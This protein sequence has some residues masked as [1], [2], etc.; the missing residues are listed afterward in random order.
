MLLSFQL[1]QLLQVQEGSIG[2]II[3][4]DL[5]SW[6]YGSLVKDTMTT[7]K[8]NSTLFLMQTNPSGKRF[9]SN[10]ISWQ[11]LEHDV[12]EI[13]RSFKTCFSFWKNAHKNFANDIQHLFD[14]TQRVTSLKQTNHYM[15]SHMAKARAIE[16]KRLIETL[17]RRT[18]IVLIMRSLHSNFDHVVIKF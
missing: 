1:L 14:A 5:H 3:R 10:Y 8:P 4:L 9:T 2:R 7:L 15:V 11:S 12:F 6:N 18:Y 17:N 16:F 13:L